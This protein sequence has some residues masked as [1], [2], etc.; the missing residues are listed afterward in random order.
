MSGG[1]GYLGGLRKPAPLSGVPGTG[2]GPGESQGAGLNWK[3]VG[4]TH[5]ED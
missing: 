3:E 2:K 5:P 4:D 1:E